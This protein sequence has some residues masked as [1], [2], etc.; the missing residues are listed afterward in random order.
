[1]EYLSA[2]E[3]AEAGVV[4]LAVRCF[5]CA[6]GLWQAGGWHFWYASAFRV[7]EAI[8]QEEGR[9]EENSSREAF[10]GLWCW[11]GRRLFL[12]VVAGWLYLGGQF[13]F[14]YNVCSG[15]KSVLAKRGG[16]GARAMIGVAFFYVRFWVLLRRARV[17]KQML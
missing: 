10:L 15:T 7:V 1:M 11:L 12:V 4:R 5:F 2:L 6:A 16:R 17:P 14:C 13:F 3:E 9:E 8:V